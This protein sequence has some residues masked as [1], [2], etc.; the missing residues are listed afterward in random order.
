MTGTAPETRAPAEAAAEPPGG[1]R[2]RDGQ[3]S[4]AG[5]LVRTARPKQW[6]KNVL[7]FAAPAAAGV[8]DDAGALAD[9]IVAFVAFCLA[10]SATYFFNDSR[11]AAADRLHPRKRHRAV[12][13]GVVSPG[14]ATAT[15]VVLACIALGISFVAS[16]ELAAVVAGYLALTVAYTI[17]LKHEAVLDLAAVAAGFV[18][19]LIAG[20][21][22]VGVPISEWFLIVAGAGSFFMVTGKR[23]A[24]SLELGDGAA[25][26][27][28]ALDAYSP[29]F[30]LYLRAL[31][32]G[33]AV[34]AYCL[35]AF[36]EADT[37]AEPVWYELSIIPFVLGVLR[38]ALL[39]DRGEGGAPEDLVLSDPPLLAVGVLWLAAFGIAVYAG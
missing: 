24:E 13:A 11:D 20:G 15:A 37:G 9:T 4:A 39:L 10:A 38:Y 17:W 1:R 3:V 30:L 27:R 23:N 32:S 16:A 21:L 36:Q 12:A 35:W 22:A 25:E 2:R 33:V 29:T 28:A 26:H 8:L 34:L 14:T 5:A 31:S 19:R 7:V 6:A 18:L